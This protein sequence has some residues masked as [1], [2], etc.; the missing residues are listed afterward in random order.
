MNQKYLF[1]VNASI[2][3]TSII[4]NFIYLA[5]SLSDCML[6][7]RKKYIPQPCD[8]KRLYLLLKRWCIHILD[9]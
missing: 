5:Q 6:G 1:V 4:I 9:I 7:K 3:N 8:L 2:T